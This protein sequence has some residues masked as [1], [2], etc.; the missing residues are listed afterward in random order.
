MSDSQFIVQIL[1]EKIA[2]TGFE[3]FDVHTVQ[4]TKLHMLDTLGVAAAGSVSSETNAVLKSLL[5]MQTGESSIWGTEQLTNSISAALINAVS[6]HALELDDSGGCDHSGA[7][8]IPAALAVLSEL[9]Y[10]VSGQ[11]LLTAIILGYEVGRRVLEA[12]G[13]YESHNNQGWHSTGT[14]GVF[15]AATTAALLMN[16]DSHKVMNALS[17]ASSFSGGTWAFI[18][19]GSQTKKLHAG[20]AA[21][22]GVL[23]AKLA[24]NGFIGPKSIFEKDTWGSFLSCFNPYDSDTALLTSNFGESWRINRCSIKPYATCRGTHSSIDALRQIIDEHHL[25]SSDIETISVRISQFQFG[26]CGKKQILSRA[27]AQM[28]IAYAMSAWLEFNSVGLK[29]LDSNIWSGNWF[30]DWFSRISFVVDGDMADDAEPEINVTTVSGVTISKT[31]YWPL[32]SPQF[33]LS[34]KEIINK[35]ETMAA[36]CISDIQINALE[37]MVLTLEEHKDV[38]NLS[39]LLALVN[40]IVISH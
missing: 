33:P 20:R 1:A 14:C 17:I 8:V 21:E 22:G 10:P 28:S 18:H 30:Y 24:A 25:S 29:E 19:D 9:P 7:V 11:Q 3:S 5:P 4:K 38:R 39:N 37:Q 32:G 23:A 27:E 12:T 35:Y 26:M 13:S 40:D 34:E 2:Q 36:V 15:G 16:L 6:A 31:V